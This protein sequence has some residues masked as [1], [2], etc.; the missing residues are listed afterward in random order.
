MAN[1]QE[2]PS[3]QEG[4][5]TPRSAVRPPNLPVFNEIKQQLIHAVET[6][7]SIEIADEQLGLLE[8][9]FADFMN[10]ILTHAQLHASTTVE[11]RLKS[12]FALFIN[13][14]EKNSAKNDMR[15]SQLYPSETFSGKFMREIPSG[16]FSYAFVEP[17]MANMHY[18]SFNSLNRTIKLRPEIFQMGKLGLL[19]LLHELQHVNNVQAIGARL[20]SLD[21]YVEFYRKKH[22]QEPPKTVID[23]EESAN[24]TEIEAL[25]L[26]MDDATRALLTSGV[27]VD[28]H[29]V[30]KQLGVP[31]NN[32]IT[33]L[34]L[35]SL[36]GFARVY[37]ANGG[38]KDNM[39]GNCS[40][41]L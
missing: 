28:I 10:K 27:D 6:R 19:V 31:N 38:R 35:R 7:S 33:L 34:A 2:G 5:N 18:S 29:S 23:D 40:L 14:A 25:A 9:S 16:F 11:S 36:L 12:A 21:S 30:M 17:D 20:G 4:E 37:Y 3:G 8:A 1:D 15:R 24:S 13:N 32:K 22:S 41:T 39:S 26:S